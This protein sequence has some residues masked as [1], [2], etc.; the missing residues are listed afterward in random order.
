[1][2]EE[3]RLKLTLGLFEV[4][5]CVVVLEEVHLVNVLQGLDS[6]SQVSKASKER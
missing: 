5:N 1:M 4:H 6:Y 2:A 3:E